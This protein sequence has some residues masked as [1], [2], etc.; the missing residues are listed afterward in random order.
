MMKE[1]QSVSVRC[2]LL[3]ALVLAG[4]YGVELW[5]VEKDGKWGYIDPS[6]R[7]TISCR[8]DHADVFEDGLARIRSADKWGFVDPHG[9]VV[10]E[11]RFDFVR[12]FS[13]GLALVWIG[14][15]P[16][17]A[18]WT[19]GEF[20]Y[21][22][23]TGRKAF[24]C[25]VDLADDFREGM[26]RVWRDGNCGYIDHKGRM[27]IEPQYHFGGFFSE[28]LASFWHGE[29]YTAEELIE[30]E[31]AAY[32]DEDDSVFVDFDGN[33]IEF[34][35]GRFHRAAHGI[36]RCNNDRQPDRDRDTVSRSV[37]FS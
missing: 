25:D 1:W 10:I 29:P 14:G 26:A 4:G 21:I 31:I 22:D 6:G 35:S 5:P 37:R 34:P 30:K 20:R 3:S 19:G 13:D 17:K 36:G 11:P 33:P 12:S 8:F 2:W 27:V 15:R 28:G 32:Y 24:D 7:I 23:K 16:G 18:G 9:K